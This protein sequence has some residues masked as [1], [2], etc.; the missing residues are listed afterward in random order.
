MKIDVVLR[1][2]NGEVVKYD[3]KL[4]LEDINTNED[5]KRDYKVERLNLELPNNN[6]ELY[7]EKDIE[8]VGEILNLINRKIIDDVDEKKLGYCL[9]AY[10]D[11]LEFVLNNIEDVDIVEVCTDIELGE[12]LV[13]ELDIFGDI[14]DKVKSYLDYEKIGRDYGMDYMKVKGA[15]VRS[16]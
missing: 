10:N 9:E 4:F 6:L 2:K 7:L 1:S 12:Y 15:Y 11:D 5:F 13:Y 14:E 8:E 3:Y 16:I